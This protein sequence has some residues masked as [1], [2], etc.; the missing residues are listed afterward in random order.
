MAATQK[1]IF[2]GAFGG[3]I[4]G[5]PAWKAIP[6]WFLLCRNDR[7]ITVQLQQYMAKRISATVV[8][9]DASHVPFLSH[10]ADVTSIIEQAAVATANFEGHLGVV[11]EPDE[12]LELP[13]FLFR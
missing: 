1:P 12:W 3:A 11:T 8:E 5:E 13:Q 2:E 7:A 9:I 4:S 6:S 10:P